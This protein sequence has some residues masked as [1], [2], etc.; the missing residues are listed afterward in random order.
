[1]HPHRRKDNFIFDSFQGRIN[2]VW[3]QSKTQ[4]SDWFRWNVW[5]VSLMCT[6][7]PCIRVRPSNPSALASRSF[8]PSYRKDSECRTNRQSAGWWGRPGSI[9]SYRLLGFNQGRPIQ[10]TRMAA[11]CRLEVK[12]WRRPKDCPLILFHPYNV[13][14]GRRPRKRQKV[15]DSLTDQSC[16]SPSNQLFIRP[17]STSLSTL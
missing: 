10:F 8:A 5:P 6:R 3:F 2:Q 16:P 13:S 11:R 1:M 17:V 12:W 9:N 15:M 14:L 7:R 4:K